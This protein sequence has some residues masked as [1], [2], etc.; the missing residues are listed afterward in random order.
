MRAWCYWTK[1]AFG[2][3]VRLVRCVTPLPAS[4]HG[5]TLALSDIYR[6]SLYS[7]HHWAVGSKSLCRTDGTGFIL[8]VPHRGELPCL[9]IGEGCH[10]STIL[11]IH[12]FSHRVRIRYYLKWIC[13]IW[14]RRWPRVNK[15][16]RSEFRLLLRH[17]LSQCS[18]T[19]H[20]S[21]SSN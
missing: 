2:S 1:L 13:I 17:Q 15:L 16:Q 14:Q 21:V 3:R 11:I 19:P 18:C 8:G 9:H 5:C 4:V 6:L 7:D 10:V 12:G 20:I